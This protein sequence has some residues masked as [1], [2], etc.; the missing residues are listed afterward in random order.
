MQSKMNLKH[1]K[2]PSFGEPRS[3]CQINQVCKEENQRRNLTF[4]NFATPLWNIRKL[5][6][7]LR[8]LQALQSWEEGISQALRNW[9]ISQPLEK[10][11]QPLVKFSQA[12]RDFASLAK[13]MNFATPCE[14]FTTLQNLLDNFRYF[15]T[16]FVR[17]L[18]HDILC[19]YLFF[20]CNQL[21][22]FLDI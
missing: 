10:F 21:K 13:L 6:N 3:L 14:I 12:K 17:F 15:C 4:N 22:I 9:W 19:N 7:C 18:S 16:D 5:V 8:G 2:N 20:P 1:M 11:S